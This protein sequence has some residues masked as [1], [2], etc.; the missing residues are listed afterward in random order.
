MYRIQFRWPWRTR[1]DIG[2][3]I[4]EELGFHLEMRTEELVG[5][6]T[7]RDAAQRPALQEFGDLDPGAEGHQ[8]GP[9]SGA[10]LG[11]RAPG[12]G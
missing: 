9:A 3:D 4:D 12:P 5:L 6:G 11:V 2:T 10:A 8:G 7:S 1:K